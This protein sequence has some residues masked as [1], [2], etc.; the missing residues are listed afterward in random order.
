MKT[1]FKITKIWAILGGGFLFAIMI[2]TFIDISSLFFNRVLQ[3]KTAGFS[4]YEDF[5]SLAI[6]AA[7]LMFIPYAQIKGAHIK[8]DLLTNKISPS[9]KFFLDKFWLSLLCTLVFFLLYSVF[10]G[11]VETYK[12]GMLTPVLSWV[13]WPAYLPAIFSLTLWFFV[14]CLQL[15]KNNKK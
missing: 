2:S 11:M 4:G 7:S 5:I 14:C 10:L 6:S 9:W 13:V 8:V 12:D 3:L 1:I 15:L